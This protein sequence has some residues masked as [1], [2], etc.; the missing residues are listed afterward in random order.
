[1]SIAAF[2]IRRK[3]VWRNFLDEVEV[4]L[5]YLK[6]TSETPKDFKEDKNYIK[7]LVKRGD[8]LQEQL[9]EDWLEEGFM[10]YKQYAMQ[11][12]RYIHLQDLLIDEIRGYIEGSNDYY[13]SKC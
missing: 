6:E 4:N 10:S 3:N 2:E 11:M 8:D 1:M 9:D 7:K 12:K 13:L 5:C